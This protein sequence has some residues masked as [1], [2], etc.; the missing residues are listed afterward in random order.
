MTELCSAA[1]STKNSVPSTAA[2]RYGVFTA[3]RRGLRLND[4]IAP[5]TSSRNERSSASAVMSTSCRVVFWSSRRTASLIREI[6]ARLRRPAR[7]ASP[8]HKLVAHGGRLPA[9]GGGPL[10][11]DLTLDGGQL[12]DDRLAGFQRVSIWGKE[13]EPQKSPKKR[14]QA[15]VLVRCISLFLAGMPAAA[16]KS[17]Q[18]LTDRVK[19]FVSSA[20]RRRVSR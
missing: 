13:G 18:F 12:P 2:L 19:C 15:A 8:S 7:T 10:H 16:R 9:R 4:W 20:G 11:F 6:A 1:T 5:T 3:S 17:R 14:A